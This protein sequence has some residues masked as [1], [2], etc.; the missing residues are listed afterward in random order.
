[1]SKKDPRA[2]SSAIV[3]GVTR[4]PSRAM[5][6]AV[7]FADA[8]FRK[9]QIGIASTWSQVTPCNMHIDRLAREAAAGADEA[10]GKS[11]VFNTTTTITSISSYL[12]YFYTCAVGSEPR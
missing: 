1:M 12:G 8:D 10:G 9:P 3:D 7:G 5:L 11:V 6:R 2:H 4:A